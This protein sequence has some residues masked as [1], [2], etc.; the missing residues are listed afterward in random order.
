MR[1]P[2]LVLLPTLLLSTLAFAG[3]SALP[4]IQDPIGKCP[5]AEPQPK[6]CP[7]DPGNGSQSCDDTHRFVEVVDCPTRQ[8]GECTPEERDCRFTCRIEINGHGG[9]EVCLVP[10]SKDWTICQANGRT[11]K[12]SGTNTEVKTKRETISADV[13][14]GGSKKY[15]V[16]WKYDDGGTTKYCCQYILFQCG[17][18][19]VVP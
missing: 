5:A 8:D 9:D 2:S 1:R 13:P 18:C 4:R 6:D 7:D 11:I 15:F 3:L 14:C 10:A 16:V 12:L 19:V 17:S